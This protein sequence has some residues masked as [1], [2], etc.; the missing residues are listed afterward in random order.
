MFRSNVGINCHMPS[1]SELDLVAG[2]G[3]SNIRVDFK[4]SDIDTKTGY[5]WTETDRVVSKANKLKLAVFA[6]LSDGINRLN[7]VSIANWPDFVHACVTRYGNRVAYWGIW[8]EPNLS[9]FWNG[10]RSDFRCKIFEPGIAAVKS[11]SLSAKIVGPDLST[12]SSSNWWKW[13]KELK[14]PLKQCDAISLHTYEETPGEVLESITRSPWYT[15]I[16]PSHQGF[17]KVLK[18]LGLNSKPLW[19][20][21]TGWYTG[22]GKSKVSENKQASNIK[23]LLDRAGAV[24]KSGKL[25]IYELTDDPAVELWGIVKKDGTKKA[26]YDQIKSQL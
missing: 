14:E 12:L 3:I 1:N 5:N 23:E 21:E 24:L 7:R 16:W 10:T 9:Q 8:N 13:L 25:Y 26:A 19:I 20:T 22:N 2:C 6:N 11:V 4:W 18:D 17:N 15:F